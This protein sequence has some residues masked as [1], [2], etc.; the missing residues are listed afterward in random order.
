MNTPLWK[1]KCVVCGAH[2]ISLLCRDCMRSPVNHKV[3]LDVAKRM[4]VIEAEYDNQNLKKL[5]G[6]VVEV[7]R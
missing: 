6:E 3:A 7:L 4:A 2:T 1:C 5:L